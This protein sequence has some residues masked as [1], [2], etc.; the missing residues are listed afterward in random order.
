MRSAVDTPVRG[1]SA[2]V[3]KEPDGVIASLI[4][5]GFLVLRPREG[6]GDTNAE[7]VLTAAAANKASRT[8]WFF[9]DK[10]VMFLI[11]SSNSFY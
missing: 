10:M 2:L 1:W 7:L 8:P 6:D 4:T 5:A 9:Q 11:L 3:T